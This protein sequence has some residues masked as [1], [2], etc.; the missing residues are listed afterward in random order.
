MA[1]RHLSRALDP[2]GVETDA[3][4]PVRMSVCRA[5]LAYPGRHSNSCR[6][7]LHTVILR[8]LFDD[9]GCCT[10]GPFRARSLFL[11]YHWNTPML[12]LTTQAGNAKELTHA[13]ISTLLQV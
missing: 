2:E 7:M 9:A 11:F 1:R 10:L 5:S 13:G 6:A 4:A 12:S 3:V 8:L